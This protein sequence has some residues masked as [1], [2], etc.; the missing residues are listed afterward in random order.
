MRV[1]GAIVLAIGC[2]VLSA[3]PARAQSQPSQSILGEL[4]S[5]FRYTANNAEADVE[6]ILTS[7]LH[8]PD[9]FGPGG[10]MR[11]PATYYT[12]IGV[13]A[14]MGGAFALDS[15]V[16]AHLRHM[17]SGDASDLETAGD[18]FTYGSAG[19]LYLY[20]LWT[21]D[22]RM[23]E[24]EITGGEGAALGSL[25]TLA[26]ESAF[27]RDRPKTGHGVGAFF[28]NGRSFTS[29]EATPVFAFAAATSEYYD[30]AWYA[31]IPAYAG[32]M[33]LGFGRMGHDA[34]W[35][36]D[37]IGAAVV[38]VGTTELLFYLHR[39]HSENPSRFRIFP[40]VSSSTAGGGITFQW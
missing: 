15:T 21:G 3:M 5:D 37:I 7:P 26:F 24:Y 28:H 17:S 10:V 33:T 38:G 40:I 4:G 25:V 35:L 30:N 29:G 12:L 8:I 19:L 16:H 27:G 34:H 32:A 9:L 6:D 13:G 18:A 11:Q 2:A 22:N 31:A 14:A 36:S 23:R 39:K 20:G 1:L